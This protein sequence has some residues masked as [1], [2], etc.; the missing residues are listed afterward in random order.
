MKGPAPDLHLFIDEAEKKAAAGDIDPMSN[1]G[2]QKVYVFHGFNDSVVAEPVTAATAEFYG[3]YLGPSGSGNLFYQNTIG[4]G[5]SQVLLRAEK[6]TGL[7]GCKVNQTPFLNQC[8]YDQAGII[9][10]HIY[11]ALN[12]PAQGRLSAPIRS[13][14]QGKY[15][16]TDRPGALSMADK[17]YM[18]VPNACEG[19]QAAP[20]RVHIAFHGCK[21]A[22]GDIGQLHV[23]DSGY[24]AWAD[25]NR[26]IVLYPQT[27]AGPFNPQACW[28]WWSYVTHD[29]SM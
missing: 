4:A 24:N 10:Q 3:H 1:L 14:D 12:P 15:T 22:A 28:D 17:G 25:A 26:I 6:E 11:G 27:T 13:F 20:C 5:H 9:L 7:N 18:F 23:E 21:Q 2:R 29:E 19:A 16:G 8:G